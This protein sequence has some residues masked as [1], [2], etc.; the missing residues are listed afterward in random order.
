MEVHCDYTGS[1]EAHLLHV[2]TTTPYLGDVYE[3]TYTPTGVT[4][5]LLYRRGELSRGEEVDFDKLSPQL[6]EKIYEKLREALAEDQRNTNESS[7]E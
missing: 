7:T 6:Q 1:E 2:T 4:S 5:I 3:I